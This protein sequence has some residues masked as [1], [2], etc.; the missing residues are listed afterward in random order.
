[1]K[2][3]DLFRIVLLL[4][5]VFSAAGCGRQE[6]KHAPPAVPVTAGEAVRKDMPVQIQAVGVVEAYRSVTVVPQATGQV[7]AVHFR[8]GQEVRKGDLLFSLDPAP[9][10]EE[11]RQA[12]ARLAKEEAQLENNRAEARRYAFLLE[13]GA[14]SRSDYERYQTTATT[15]SQTVRDNRA[16]AG[17]ARLNLQYCSIRAPIAGKT[18]TYGVNPGAVVSANTGTLTTVN[19][20]RPVY[21]R[22]SIPES[23]LADVRR[24]MRQSPLKV[25][26]TLPGKEKDARE[27][28]LVFVDNTVDPD[29]GMIRLKAEFAN[30]DGFL[31]PGQFANAALE[32]TIQKNALV[33]PSPAVQKSQEGH[34]VF[35]IRQ[36]KT[37]VQRPVTV[38][39]AVGPE[40]V[41]AKGVEPGEKVVT[42]GHL[43]L[44]EGFPVETKEVKKA[45]AGKP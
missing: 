38:D 26:A 17:K 43:K 16:A 1:M 3:K 34:Y 29:S 4:V 39:R 5:I 2:K 6:A 23:Q 12:E 30:Q 18:G 14:V 20:I 33:V 15:Q 22:F 35:V 8:E 40:T 44:R 24:R 37:V 31:W 45:T 19:Q 10:Q 41:L 7:A 9:F 28:V 11:L 21:V 32:L 36:D 25:T 42:D 27:G 13:K